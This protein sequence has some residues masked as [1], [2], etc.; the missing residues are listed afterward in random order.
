MNADAPHS[1]R[2][3]GRMCSSAFVCVYLRFISETTKTVRTRNIVTFSKI[4]IRK[5]VSTGITFVRQEYQMQIRIRN[6]GPLKPIFFKIQDF[7]EI[8][9][10]FADSGATGIIRMPAAQTCLCERW[11]RLLSG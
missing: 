11:Q 6:F 2:L 10:P 3:T 1:E 5:D 9:L 7:N 8:F 4:R